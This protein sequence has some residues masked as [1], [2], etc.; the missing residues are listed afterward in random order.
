MEN[1]E[2]QRDAVESALLFFGQKP[3]FVS[4]V[5]LQRRFNA[6]T[7][8][9][10]SIDPTIPMPAQVDARQMSL[11][12][13]AWTVGSLKYLLGSGARSLTYYETVGERGIMMGDRDSRWP[14]QFLAR[15]GMIYPS[16]HVFRMLLGNKAFRMVNLSSNAPLHVDGFA[17]A[18]DQKGLL[19]LSNM[20]NRNHEVILKGL[21]NYR[22]MFNM[23][24]GNYDRITRHGLT[25]QLNKEG[26]ILSA[27]LPLEFRPY[28]TLFLEFP[29]DQH[30]L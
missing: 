3:V 12:G 4:P 17:L 18:D 25:D 20:T 23:Y 10:E 19:F 30:R 5:T 8:N 26:Q 28:E 29:M 7:A 15:K 9:Y 21:E 6:N 13:A 16:Y 2:A 1:T 14:L 22:L 11:Y 27:E 24:T